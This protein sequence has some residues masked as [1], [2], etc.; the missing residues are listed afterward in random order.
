M[1]QYIYI[2]ELKNNLH[3]QHFTK[4]YIFGMYVKYS[5]VHT[6]LIHTYIHTNIRKRAVQSRKRGYV[7]ER[8]MRRP[9]PNVS[10]TLEVRE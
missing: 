8:P 2:V 1:L 6:L 9:P 10:P 4:T 3:T 5:T 7:R